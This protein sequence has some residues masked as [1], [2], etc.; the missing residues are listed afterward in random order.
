[1]WNAP[2]YLSIRSC[3]LWTNIEHVPRQFCII[4]LSVIGPNS[5]KLQCKQAGNPST[6]LTIEKIVP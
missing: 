3:H 6:K 4:N 2:Y 5:S 1:M